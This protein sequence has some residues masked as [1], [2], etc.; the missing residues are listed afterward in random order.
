M[1][2]VILFL[3]V[4]AELFFHQADAL[5]QCTFDGLARG[6]FLRGS[7]REQFYIR[8]LIIHI[9][10]WDANVQKNDIMAVAICKFRETLAKTKDKIADFKNLLYLYSIV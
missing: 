10:N 2:I 9:G 4:F 3:F 7:P 5:G 1:K 8:G 6:C